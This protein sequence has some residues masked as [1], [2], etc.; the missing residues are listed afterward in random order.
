MNRISLSD[1]ARQ[2]DLT[3]TE[4]TAHAVQAPQML[5]ATARYGVC[6]SPAGVR[7]WKWTLTL[8]FSDDSE[9]TS[10][11]AAEDA[12]DSS[13]WD[14]LEAAVIAHGRVWTQPTVYDGDGC[15]LVWEAP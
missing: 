10:D 8:T 1:Y 13:A 9:V 3:A 12:D 11:M 2:H 6:V 4:A 7:E 5:T 14:E 15:V